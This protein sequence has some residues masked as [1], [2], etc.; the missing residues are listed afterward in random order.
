MLPTKTSKTFAQ[1]N[2]LVPLKL[3][4]IYFTICMEFEWLK[5]DKRKMEGEIIINKIREN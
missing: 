2:I 5:S 4:E 3:N 1:T